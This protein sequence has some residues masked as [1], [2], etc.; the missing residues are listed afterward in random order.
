MKSTSE[1]KHLGV[2]VPVS[3]WEALKAAA[4]KEDLT[5]TQLVRKLVREF[6]AKCSESSPL[7]VKK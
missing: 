6:L 2:R 1:T 3:M 4:D 7:E 5:V